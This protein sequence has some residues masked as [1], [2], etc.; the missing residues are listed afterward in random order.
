MATKRANE[1]AARKAAANLALA[2]AHRRR[3]AATLSVLR[4]AEKIT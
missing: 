4:K 2:S 3:V 1:A